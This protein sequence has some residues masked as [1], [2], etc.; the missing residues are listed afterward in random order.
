MANK[1][2]TDK[3]NVDFNFEE[4]TTNVLRS[5]DSIRSSGR[6][7]ANQKVESRVNA[8]YRGLGI[9]AVKEVSPE[10]EDKK[11]RG[12]KLDKLNNNNVVPISEIEPSSKD[13]EALVKK[14][15]DREIDSRRD[16]KQ[17]EID[18]FIDFNKKSF[19][20]NI[21]DGDNQDRKRARGS[22]FPIIVNGDIEIYSD[23]KRVTGAFQTDARK[24]QPLGRKSQRHHIP[25]IESIIVM[26]LRAEGA[27][28][29]K[30]E[31]AVTGFLRK[32][33]NIL[34]EEIRDAHTAG[35]A[36]AASSIKKTIREAGRIRK[37]LGANMI[38]TI[39]NIPNR[40]PVAEPSGKRGTTDKKAARIELRGAV[41]AARINLIGWDDTSFESSKRNLKDAFLA[42]QAIIDVTAS[43]DGATKKNKREVNQEL[44]GDIKRAKQVFAALDSALGT[45]SGL[46][47]V[48]VLI[49]VTALYS[50]NVEYL[51]GLL[52]REA[53]DRLKATWTSTISPKTLLESK[54]KLEAEVKDLFESLERQIKNSKIKNENK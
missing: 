25:L 18:V 22:L 16:I 5:V 27:T 45:F 33:F 14:L 9:P 32:E 52:N 20:G 47:G 2:G 46:S 1:K 40:D 53:R 50:L 48:D 8:F 51:A 21:D 44:E 4:F 10:D 23:S 13:Q 28:N 11:P 15:K 39:F 12:R 31:G 42:S 24:F 34:D 6:S 38:P 29:T 49:V 54:N 17:D 35:I 30:S 41:S 26:K 37:K 7:G 43:A 19:I 3:K 36:S